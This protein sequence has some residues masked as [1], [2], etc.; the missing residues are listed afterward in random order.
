MIIVDMYPDEGSIEEAHL[1]V[2]LIEIAF[3]LTDSN[4]LLALNVPPKYLKHQPVFKTK[5]RKG[6][7]NSFQSEPLTSYP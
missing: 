2:V 7:E 1:L 6:K 5:E 4:D 3:C